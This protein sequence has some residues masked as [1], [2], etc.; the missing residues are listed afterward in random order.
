MTDIKTTQSELTIIGTGMAGMA[1]AIFAAKKG[2]ETVQI[3]V[4]SS[5]IY[6]TGYLD[7]LGVHPIKHQ[8]TWDNPWHAIDELVTDI[9]N[10]PYARLKQGQRACKKFRIQGARAGKGRGVLFVR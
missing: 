10:H 5:T 6:A 1:A 8:K 4:S 7:L 2:I 3:G 9:P